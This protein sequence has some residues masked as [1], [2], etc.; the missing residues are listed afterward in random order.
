MPLWIPLWVILA[1]I[2]GML[3]AEASGCLSPD[4]Y[5]AQTKRPEK[6]ICVS[7]STAY[8]DACSSSASEPPLS[9]MA[10]SASLHDIAGDPGNDG[11]L[12]VPPNLQHLT[13]SIAG[14]SAVLKMG[15]LSRTRTCAT[16]ISQNHSHLARA[17]NIS[18]P[19]VCRWN[20]VSPLP[21]KRGTTTT[22]CFGPLATC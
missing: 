11:P 16:P 19:L 13:C 15:F 4:I 17:T 12:S 8:L 10:D 22:S 9:E 2:D 18:L 20:S 1:K 21:F 3:P 5:L 7:L 6:G 14:P